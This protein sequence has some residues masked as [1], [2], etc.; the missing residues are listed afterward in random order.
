MLDIL[1]NNSCKYL[2]ERKKYNRKQINIGVN[3]I[4]NIE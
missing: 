1:R 4:I 2:K 3:R